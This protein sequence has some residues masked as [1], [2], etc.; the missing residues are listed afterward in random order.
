MSNFKICLTIVLFG[1]I[2]CKDKDLTAEITSV[3]NI[4]IIPSASGIEVIDNQIFIIG[5][6]SPWLFKL[7]TNLKLLDKI[8]LHQQF[9]RKFNIIPKPIKPDYE[10]LNRFRDGNKIKLMVFCS[11]SIRQTRDQLIIIDPATGQTRPYSLTGLYQYLIKIASLKAEDLNIE[12]AVSSD[13]HLYLFNRGKNLIFKCL[14]QD[15]LKYLETNTN[16]PDFE[17]TAHELPKLAGIEAGFSGA[18]ITPDQSKILFTASVENTQNWIDDGEV[19]GSFI[20]SI[21][22]N[23]FHLKATQLMLQNKPLLAKVESVAIKK[24]SGNHYELL[25]VTDNDGEASQIITMNLGL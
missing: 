6:N 15:L 17:I 4:D 16:V 13:K 7:D 3:K 1:L 22:L 23:N 8:E 2:S 20:G 21:D 14:L 10:A 25:L 12:A 19:T 24:E 5:D 18:C 11:G 9:S